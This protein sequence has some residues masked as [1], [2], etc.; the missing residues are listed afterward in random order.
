MQIIDREKE[1]NVLKK[2]SQSDK[3]ELVMLYGRRRVGKTTLAIKFKKE[4]GA[5]YLLARETTKTD[6]LRHFSSIL[7]G[8]LNDRMLSINLLAN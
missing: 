2:V 8:E 7:A 5:I 4:Y 3:S 6:N 1:M